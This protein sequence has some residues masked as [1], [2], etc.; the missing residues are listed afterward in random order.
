MSWLYIVISNL[1]V[2][3]VLIVEILFSF[4]SALV[5]TASIS[6]VFVAILFVL[7]VMFCVFA[8]MLFVLFV[9]FWLFVATLLFVVV[10]PYTM[11]YNSIGYA[12]IYPAGELIQ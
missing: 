6:W 2:N 7:V 1:F 10:N 4:V 11:M 9:M 5:L 3:V 12:N 8:A